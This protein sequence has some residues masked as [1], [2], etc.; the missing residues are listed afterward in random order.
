MGP[1]AMI[2]VF[3]ML[4]FKPSFSLSSLTLIL[5]LFSSFTLSAIRVV[6]SA[7]LR[8]LM[9][10]L[11][12]LHFSL[13]F[14]QHSIL[15]DTAAYKLN[16]QGD[17]IQPCHTHFP[18]LNQSVVP[19]KVLSVASWP[20]Y[21]FLRRWLRWSGILI[22]LRIFQFV[23]IHTVKGF[24]IVNEAVDVFLEFPCFMIQQLITYDQLLAIWSLVCLPFLNPFIYLEVLGSHTVEA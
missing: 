14:I 10:L 5:R 20:T 4:S 17:N 8:L 21:R 1:V 18:I 6:L 23:V 13:W 19:C 22:S 7:Y 12:S 3:W 15:H 2:L 24:S 11:G 9:F 16:K